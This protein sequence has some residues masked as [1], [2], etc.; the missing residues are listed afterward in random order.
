MKK[1]WQKPLLEIL[2]VSM[3]MA[4]PGRVIADTM[5][6]HDPDEGIDVVITIPGHHS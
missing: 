4:G 2:D 3:T 5:T 1:I 6:V